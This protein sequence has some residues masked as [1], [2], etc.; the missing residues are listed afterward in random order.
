[1]E[2]K[3]QLDPPA[4]RIVLRH[5]VLAI[6]DNADFAFRLVP[7]D[8]KRDNPARQ[9]A[10]WALGT[11]MHGINVETP[12]SIDRITYIETLIKGLIE[13]VQQTA[14]LEQQ[15]GEIPTGKSIA[16]MIAVHS[17]IVENLQ[18]LAQ[19]DA[20]K[21]RVRQYGDVLKD[22]MNKVKQFAQHLEEHQKAIAKDQGEMAKTQLLAMQAQVKNQIAVSQAKLKAVLEQAKFNADEQRKNL[23]LSASLQREGVATVADIQSLTTTTRA[24]VEA[25]DARTTAEIEALDRKTTAGIDALK[26]TTEAKAEAARK[27]AQNKPD[28]DE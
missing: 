3:Q 27:S 4:Q 1:M 5:Y 25:L 7:D 12:Q 20:E 9:K 14:A 19:D 6:T 26:R 18:V 24:N 23:E 8:E 21:E 17:E 11:L 22:A 2:I 15:A 28:K 13:V 10:E 16:G